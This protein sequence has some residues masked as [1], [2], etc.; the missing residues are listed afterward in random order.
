MALSE[1]SAIEA[2]YQALQPLDDAGRRRALRWLSDALGGQDPLAAATADTPAEVTPDNQSPVATGRTVKSARAERP[3]RRA[4]GQP[5]VRPA[6]R[7][8]AR[9]DAASAPSERNYRRMP[10]VDDV[11]AAYR[12]TGSVSALADHFGVPRHTVQGW[13]RRLRRE[14]Y[15]IGRQR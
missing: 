10:P 5:I 15:E 4:A 13:A 11:M 9:A 7:G 12:E 2:A 3:G 6:R 1:L 14:G 8:R